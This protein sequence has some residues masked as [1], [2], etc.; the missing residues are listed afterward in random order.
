MDEMRIL[1][2]ADLH[3]GRQYNGLSLEVDHDAVLS[4]IVGAPIGERADVLVIAGDV[5]DRASPPSSAISQFNRFVT[6]GLVAYL[7]RPQCSFKPLG[8]RRPRGFCLPMLSADGLGY[9][10][11]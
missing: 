3:L 10:S 8:F 9:K 7:C 1:H 4:Q 11:R 6:R 5:F 2:T